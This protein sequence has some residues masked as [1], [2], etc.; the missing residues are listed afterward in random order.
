MRLAAAAEQFAHHRQ[1]SRPVDARL[2]VRSS[3]VRRAR[4]GRSA[5]SSP[6]ASI[7]SLRVRRYL[8][9]ALI[10]D[11]TA[12]FDVP[13]GWPVERA[14]IFAAGQRTA[15][16]NKKRA[17]FWRGGETHAQRKVY[18]S[19]LKSDGSVKLP[20]GVAADAVLCARCPHCGHA[21]ARRRVLA[22]WDRRLQVRCALQ[23][24]AG[25]QAGGLVL[26]PAAAV[27]PWPLVRGWVQVYNALQ[28]ARRPRRPPGAKR[29]FHV[30]PTGRPADSERL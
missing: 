27:A 13:R 23:P 10:A 2:L 17:L 6:R 4:C 8:T 3:R 14:A 7:G 15:W 21:R 9:N 1:P 11:P 25:C 30:R 12:S 26:Q 22:E 5:F 19:A 20:A 18:S 16:R 24:R 29:E 28:L